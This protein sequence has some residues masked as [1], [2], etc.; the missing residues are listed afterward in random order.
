MVGTVLVLAACG[1]AG[2]GHSAV[3]PASSVASPVSS[4]SSVA[5]SVAPSAGATPTTRAGDSASAGG[6]WR[7][8]AGLSWQWQLTTPVDTSVVA[9]VY[10]VDSEDNPAAVVAALHRA[11]RR[12][13]CYVNAGSWEPYRADAGNY[14]KVLLG[15]ALDGWPDERW[16]DIRRLDLLT[17]LLAHRLDTCKAKGFDG[18]EPDN[19]DGYTNDTG[20]PLTSAD[21]LAFDRTVARLAHRR[22]L[23]VGLKNDFDQ[24]AELQP[25]FDFGVDEQCAEQNTCAVLSA[26]VA[27]GKPVFDAEYAVSTA[28]FCERTRR[29]GISA[30]RKHLELDAWRETC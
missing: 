25:E 29:L 8:R 21:Q 10:D 7:P 2:G 11:G 13:I 4:V 15:K 18:V 12:A 22:G 30:I 5:A 3:A 1:S 16:L 6:W 20:F 17:P 14:P 9:D 23:A 26:F 24:V 27:A 28:G 19:V